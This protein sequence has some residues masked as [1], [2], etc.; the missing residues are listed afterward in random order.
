MA[1]QKVLDVAGVGGKITLGGKV[2]AVDAPLKF[3]AGQSWVAAGGINVVGGGSEIRLT[4]PASSVVEPANPTAVTYGFNPV[5]IYFNAQTYGDAGLSLYNTSYA[6][7]DQC[8]YRADKDAA[9]GLLLDSNVSLQCYFNKIN[10]PRAFASGVGGVGIRFTRGANANQVFGGKCGSSTRGMEFLSL[11]SGN[12]IAGTDFEN[13]TDR[14]IR[15]D[16]PNNMFFGVHMETAPIG[17]DI[18]VNGTHTV[19]IGTSFATNVTVQVQDASVHGAVLETRN[20]STTGGV[21]GELKFGPMRGRSSYFTTSSICMIDFDIYNS[22]AAGLIQY[23][24]NMV[25]SGECSVSY[26]KGDGSGVVTIKLNAST[27]E[28]SSRDILQSDNAG[29]NTR[30]VMRRASIPTS[31]FYNVGDVVERVNPTAANPVTRWVCIA[32]GSPGT[33]QATAWIVV[34]GPTSSRPNL[35]AADVG[36]E[37]LDT[38]L[39]GA[40]KPIRWTGAAWVDMA[41]A[42]V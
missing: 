30:R 8:A 25:T 21:T 19:R 6:K 18:T 35:G 24:R 20:D 28:I 40:G 22:A 3:Y 34:R 23:F 14:H 17:F 2:Y 32:G 31:G 15:V 9:A 1:C 39:V 37:Y 36:V 41:G 27:G 11:S 5:G 12:Y 42:I 4:A 7:P 38:T 10:Q 13:N 16:A 33:W 29:A 26:Y